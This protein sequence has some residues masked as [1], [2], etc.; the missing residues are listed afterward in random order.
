[1]CLSK[2]NKKFRNYFLNKDL[3]LNYSCQSTVVLREE[4]KNSM[5]KINENIF[6]SKLN[7]N[8]TSPLERYLDLTFQSDLLLTSYNYF[9]HLSIQFMK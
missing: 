7:K 2:I 9:N 1:M 6:Y 8:T 4:K 5:F 3:T